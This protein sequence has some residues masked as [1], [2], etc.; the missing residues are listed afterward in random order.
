MASTGIILPF[1]THV[2]CTT[3][4]EGKGKGALH[5]RKGHEDPEG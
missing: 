1:F 5:P 4:L 3:L 2:Q